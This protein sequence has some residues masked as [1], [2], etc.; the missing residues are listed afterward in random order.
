M[1]FIQFNSCQKA[2]TG[3]GNP[4]Y[5]SRSEIG[6]TWEIVSSINPFSSFIYSIYAILSI[7]LNAQG[8]Q[9]LNNIPIKITPN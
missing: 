8:N 9:N 4:S 7:P 6:S 1:K 2:P 3:G 5:F